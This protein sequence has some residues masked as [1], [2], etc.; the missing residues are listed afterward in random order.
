MLI[1]LYT[2]KNTSNGCL[3]R[4]GG[5]GAECPEIWFKS[6]FCQQIWAGRMFF[7]TAYA[8]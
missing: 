4:K 7:G 5:I 1:I 8:A 2:K 3:S 6:S